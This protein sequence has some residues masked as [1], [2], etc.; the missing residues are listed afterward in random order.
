[1]VL[2]TIISG[3]RDKERLLHGQDLLSDNISSSYSSGYRLQRLTG[4]GRE[5]HLAPPTI[6]RN[7]NMV[8]GLSF[9]FLYVVKYVGNELH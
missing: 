1:M 4:K 5:L 6:F 7:I 3:R 9:N 2:C 8:L